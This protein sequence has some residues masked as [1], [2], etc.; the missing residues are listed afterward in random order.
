ME[1]KNLKDKLKKAEISK[2]DFISAMHDFHK[3]LFDFAKNLKQTEIAK[4][5]F[6]DASKNK[7]YPKFLQTIDFAQLKADVP[8]EIFNYL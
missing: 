8:V 3:V 6:I 5:E 4:I 7:L 1:I 2:A